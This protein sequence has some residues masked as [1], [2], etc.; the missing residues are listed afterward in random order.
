MSTVRIPG[1]RYIQ[2]LPQY[3]LA[4]VHIILSWLIL[5]MSP[6]AVPYQ[7]SY[8]RDHKYQSGIYFNCFGNENSLASCRSFTSSSCDEDDAAGVHC[9]GEIITGIIEARIMQLILI[10]MH[11]FHV[12]PLT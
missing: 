2:A 7:N 9:R 1:N 3:M 10:A 8:F 6:D 5:C 4:G 12:I 11:R